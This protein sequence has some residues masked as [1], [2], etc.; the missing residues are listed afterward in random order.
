MD[1]GDVAVGRVLLAMALEREIETRDALD[2][3][4]SDV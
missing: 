2:V 3:V 1:L 4:Q